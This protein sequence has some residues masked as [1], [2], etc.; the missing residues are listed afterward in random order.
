MAPRLP[1]GAY[2]A[3][4]GETAVAARGRSPAR[5][6]SLGSGKVPSV[7]RTALLDQGSDYRFRQLV[8]DILAVCARVQAIR[9]EFGRTAGLTGPQYSLIVAIAH[10]AESEAGTT[11]NQL[12][13]HLHVS[14]TYVTAEANKLEAAG[15]LLRAPNPKDKR[16]VLLKL[17]R[18]GLELLDQ[19][20]PVIR[21]INDEIFRDLARADFELLVRLMAGLAESAADAL[22][23]ARVYPRKR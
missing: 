4:S 7:S 15:L 3:E 22:A 10:L 23:L 5:R 20:I 12:A 11:V 6:S 16:S 21:R 19:M 18:S 13:N 1:E 14:G 2:V 17:T 9:E 8:Q